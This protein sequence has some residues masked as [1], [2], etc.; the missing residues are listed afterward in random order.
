M[1]RWTQWIIP[2][3]LVLLVAGGLQRLL[4]TRKAQQDA[5]ATA[6]AN[7]AEAMVELATT[8]VVRAQ[9]RELAQGMPISGAL[10]AANSAFIKAR[11]AG[12]LQALT[13]REG[14]AVKAG[15]II[16]RVDPT[17]YLAR[18]KQAQ[19]Q[20]AA[21]KAQIDIAQRQFDN[22]KAL[23]D[24]GFISRTALET[25]QASLQSAQATYLAARAATDVARKAMDDTVLQAPISGVVAQRLA[26]SGER[27]A[28]DARIVE[29][30]DLSRIEL[31]ATL[32]AT[33]A[34][35]VRVG[36]KATLTIEGAAQPVA[37][38]VVRINPSAQGGSRAVLAYL[39][40]DNAQGLRQ[41]L[42]AQGSLDTARVSVLS[43]PLSAVRTDK[44]EPYVQV[45]EN[46][47]VVHKPVQTGVQGRAQDEIMVGVTG[48]AQ[49]ALAIRGSVGP[50][51]EGTRVKFTAAASAPAASASSPKPGV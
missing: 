44:P 27:I 35:G 28:V 45:V 10:K 33:D 21:A 14:D 9:S 13:V 6:A 5:V 48:L 1:K 41:G 46:N 11:V 50:L 36:Q 29:I 39:S 19:E 17:E 49:N 25:T 18:L 15:Q 47:V 30:V 16:A 8:D 22:N 31:E 38:T 3:V 32:P 20:G 26:Q 40:V 34:I 12:E 24:Q 4:S 37:A 51:R 23:V 42:F 43:V 7:K 2:A